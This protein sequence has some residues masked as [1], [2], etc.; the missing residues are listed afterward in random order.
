M[1][2]QAVALNALAGLLRQ[3][4]YLAE[5]TGPGRVGIQSM[6]HHHASG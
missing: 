2:M 1:N 3:G 4:M 5:M 6:Y